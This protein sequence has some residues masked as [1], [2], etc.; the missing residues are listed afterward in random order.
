M[1]DPTSQTLQVSRGPEG[2]M[3]DSSTGSCVD[4]WILCKPSFLESACDVYMALSHIRK[5]RFC[6]TG[7]KPYIGYRLVHV[8]TELF[9]ILPFL[10]EEHPLLL[11]YWGKISKTPR[12]LSLCLQGEWPMCPSHSYPATVWETQ[13]GQ[14]GEGVRLEWSFPEYPYRIL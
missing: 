4:I 9:G 3:G 13:V 12:A 14:D 6:T 11:V 1:Q 10:P 8:C 2:W 7:R 5:F